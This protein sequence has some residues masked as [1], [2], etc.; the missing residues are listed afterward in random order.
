MED[1]FDKREEWTDEEWDEYIS[2]RF[3]AEAVKI[4]ESY[5]KR[6]EEVLANLPDDD[7]GPRRRRRKKRIR[8]ALLAIGGLA[9]LAGALWAVKRLL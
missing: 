6:I 1:D 2:R 7:D 4:P 8:I 5:Y 3:Q 9:A